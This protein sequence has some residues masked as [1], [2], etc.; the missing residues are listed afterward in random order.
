[1][2]PL[3]ALQAATI[4]PARMLE[5]DGDTG[6]LTVGKFADIV[7]ID[8]NPL[9]DFKAL[10]S[11]GFVMKGGPVYRKDWGDDDA[12]TVPLPDEAAGD[13]HYHDPF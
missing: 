7:A 3:G 9:E 8:G 11:L 12:R 2:T 1:M 5:A 4:Q 10:R 13:E 6:S